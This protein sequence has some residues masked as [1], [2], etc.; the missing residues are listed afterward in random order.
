MIT[1][2]MVVMVVVMIVRM[3]VVVI[4]VIIVVEVVVCHKYTRVPQYKN[5]YKLLLYDKSIAG[6]HVVFRLQDGA[7]V[8]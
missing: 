8:S 5:T 7:R 6:C 4:I 2:G 3:I 1:V